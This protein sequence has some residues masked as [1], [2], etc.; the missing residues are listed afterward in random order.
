M[1]R[2]QR[3]QIRHFRQSAL[4]MIG[5]FALL[6]FAGFLVAGLPGVAVTALF[7]LY[8]LV[9]APRLPLDLT[10]KAAGAVPLQH[11]QAPA[12]FVL[13]REIAQ[14]A[15]LARV[16]RLYVLPGSH[17]NAFAAGREPEF[18]LAVT[19]GLLRALNPRQLRAVIA[20]E[21]SH[22]VHRDTEIM[23]AANLI[24]RLTGSMAGFGWLLLA[25]SVPLLLFTDGTV[26]FALILTLIGVPLMSN[27]LV[28]SLSRTREFEADLGAAKISGD[29]K[30][31]AE[32]LQILEQPQSLWQRLMRP[33]RPR[34]R[35]AW[36]DTHPATALR[37]ERL[38]AYARALRH[39]ASKPATAPTGSLPMSQVYLARPRWAE[40]GVFAEGSVH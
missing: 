16:P 22:M 30:A 7:A 24:N 31:L 18:G 32:A 5:L 29:P 6:S 11:H 4:L 19:E 34:H 20:H 40:F 3:D 36:L 38:Q 2:L 27:L 13:V 17:R 21:I 26:P 10:M 23:A 8:L 14:A 12:L 28:S 39:T 37:V 15:G 33:Y 1:A 9:F 25:L 35:G